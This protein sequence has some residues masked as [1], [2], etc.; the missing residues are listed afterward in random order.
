MLEEP[1][2]V[3]VGVDGTERSID[4]LRCAAVEAVRRGCQLVAVLAFGDAR[5]TAPYAPVPALRPVDPPASAAHRL[6]IV[7]R[8]AFGG[9]PPVPVREVCDPRPAVP[10]LLARAA[11]A[12]LLVLAT[13]PEPDR[14][15]GRAGH[16]TGST[17][18]ACVRHA[19]CPV[20]LLPVPRRQPAWPTALPRT[21]AAAA[22]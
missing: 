1:G 9:L 5:L 15:S 17:A 13:S 21:A 18:L 10:A 20:L 4:A 3:V 22:T 16:A 12:E 14:P 6:A 19:P 8:A 7:V 2:V 11:G